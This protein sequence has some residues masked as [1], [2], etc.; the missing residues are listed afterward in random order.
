MHTNMTFSC[1]KPENSQKIYPTCIS[2][3]ELF[4]NSSM[5]KRSRFAVIDVAETFL[6]Y[7]IMC[8]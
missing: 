5:I 4:F 1:L 2:R 6:Y 8:S 7:L 3:L